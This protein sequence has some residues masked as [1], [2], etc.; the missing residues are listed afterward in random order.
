MASIITSEDGRRRAL[1]R[2]KNATAAERKKNGAALNN[3]SPDA[4][5]KRNRENVLKRWE[6][7]REI[8]AE[9]NKSELKPKRVLRA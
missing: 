9:Q 3:L 8:K 2:W 7:H 5:S 6:R 4:L 1:I